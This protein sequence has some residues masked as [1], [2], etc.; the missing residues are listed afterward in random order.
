MA[1]GV[2]SLREVVAGGLLGPAASVVLA[3]VGVVVPSPLCRPAITETA[4]MRSTTAA[5]AVSCKF[6]GSPRNLS[7]ACASRE[8]LFGLRKVISLQSARAYA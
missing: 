7:Q 4:T 6:A 1:A 5:A 3:G 2:V 8:V